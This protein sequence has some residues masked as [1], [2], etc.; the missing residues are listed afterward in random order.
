[1]INP[2]NYKYDCNNL[3]NNYYN[4]NIQNYRLRSYNY[5][6]NDY[7]CLNYNYSTSSPKIK[8]DKN[9]DPCCN[10]FM[11]YYNFYC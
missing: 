9:C 7:P 3:N 10:K 5:G 6:R 1:M 2:N 11:D 4:Y 8:N